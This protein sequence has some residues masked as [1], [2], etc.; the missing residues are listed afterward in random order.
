[1]L[2]VSPAVALPG[3]QIKVNCAVRNQGGGAHTAMVRIYYSPDP[4]IAPGDLA[5]KELSFTL[6]VNG[7]AL[8]QSVTLTLPQQAEPGARYIGAL[9]D[10]RD[11]I[12]EADETNNSRAANIAIQALAPAD[13]KLSQMSLSSTRV[14]PGGGVQVSFRAHNAGAKTATA[15]VRIYFSTGPAFNSAA[16]QLGEVSVTLEAFSSTPLHTLAVQ[17][18]DQATPGTRYII[19]RIDPEDSVPE[20]NESNNSLPAL[21]LVLP[22]T[23]GG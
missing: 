5:I 8:Q 9:V 21:L 23:P 11:L 1:M 3:A 4:A 10:P 13:L 14:S 7:T 20:S 22:P 12:S 15:P 17:M 6:P 19:A 18:P 16:I 2:T